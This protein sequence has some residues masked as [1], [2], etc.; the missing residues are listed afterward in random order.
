MPT[1]SAQLLATNNFGG[2]EHAQ[3]WRLRIESPDATWEKS[4]GAR[5][6]EA[7]FT[8]LPILPPF[9]VEPPR[10]AWNFRSVL[11]RF[12][13]H[14]MKGDNCKPTL[15]PLPWHPL[16][17]S[18]VTLPRAPFSFAHSTLIPK[19]VARAGRPADH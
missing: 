17:R 6:Q 15:P 13:R 1:P 12:T 10:L 3:D 5:L 19:A 18:L 16:Y 4:H 9:L 14:S 11:I 7:M 2:H 8:R